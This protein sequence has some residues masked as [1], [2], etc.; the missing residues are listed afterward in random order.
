MFETI[1][2]ILR[3]YASISVATTTMSSLVSVFVYKRRFKKINITKVTL[4]VKVLT[5]N[6]TPVADGKSYTNTV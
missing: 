1:Y 5:R 2:L 6:V 3:F 4:N